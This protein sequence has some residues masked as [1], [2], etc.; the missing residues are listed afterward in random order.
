MLPCPA[1]DHVNIM[2]NLAELLAVSNFHVT[3]LNTTGIDAQFSDSSHLQLLSSI[4]PRGERE[5]LLEI[6][7]PG[8]VGGLFLPVHRAL[9]D[10][11][12]ILVIGA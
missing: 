1:Q 5:L 3:F 12:L 10:A 11:M 2:L 7:G 6:L 4:I 9:P 8:I